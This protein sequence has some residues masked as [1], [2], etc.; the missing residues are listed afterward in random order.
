M[1]LAP[2]LSDKALRARCSWRSRAPNDRRSPEVAPCRIKLLARFGG[3]FEVRTLDDGVDR[4]GLLAQPAIDTFDHIN[5]VAGD[6]A[7][8]VVPA[9]AGRKAK[10]END[11]EAGSVVPMRRPN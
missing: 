2:C 6:T 10:R 8:A 1:S 4:A 7:G 5:V 3:V 11:N 9:W